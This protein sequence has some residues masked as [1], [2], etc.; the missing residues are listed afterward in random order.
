MLE[1]QEPGVATSGKLGAELAA[2]ALATHPLPIADAIAALLAADSEF[3]QRDRVVEVF[4]VELRLLAALVLAARVQFGAGAQGDSPQL[5]ELLRTLRSRGLTD[6][7]WVAL[8]REI[9]RPYGGRGASPH[10]LAELVGLMF[11][12]KSELP[13]LFDELLV[14]RKSETVAHGATGTRSSVGTVLERRVPQLARTLAL[15]DP[16]WERVRVVVPLA[17]PDDATEPQP[18]WVLVGGTPY[19]GRFR[20]GA[21]AAG[22]R[23]PAGEALLV[24]AEGKPIIALHPIVLVRKPSPETY[25]EVFLLD[26]SSKKGAV[27][28]AVPSMAEHREA[29]AWSVIDA[30]LDEAALEA[31]SEAPRGQERPFRGLSS[32]GPEH[33]A[34]FFG[35]EEQ[36]ER[37]ANRVRRNGLTT[38]TGPSGSGKTSL[39]SAG[40]VPLLRDATA[41]VL[42]PGADPLAS[43]AAALSEVGPR[44][45]LRELAGRAPR[46]LADEVDR[47]ARERD[48]SIIVI[49]DQAEELLTLTPS[50]ADREAFGRAI[51]ALASGHART[52][53]VLSVREDFFARLATIGPLAGVYNLH[54]EVVTTPDR[55]AL[56]RTLIAPAMAFGYA[57]EDEALVTSMLDDV[58]GAP[59]ALALLSFCADQLWDR[60]DRKWKRLTWDAYRALGGVAGA[61][62]THADATLAKLTASE[63]RTCRSLFLRLVTG[64]RTRAVAHVAELAAAL[65]DPAEAKVVIERLA[66]ARLLTSREDDSETHDS[67]HDRERGGAVVEIVHEALIRHWGEL[68]RWLSEDVDGQRLLA[69]MRA[70]TKEWQSRDR[71]RSLLWSGDLLAELERFRRRSSDALAG[72]EAEFADA[73]ALEARRGRRIRIGLHRGCVRS[74]RRFLLFSLTQWRASERA[75][76]ALATEQRAT[77][78]QKTQA[79]VRGLVAEARGFEPRGRSDN[80]LALLRA[81]SS[82]EAELGETKETRLSLDLERLA[83]SGAGGV[84]LRGHTGPVY[85]TCALAGTPW[86]VTAGMD[87]SA[88]VW[89]GTTGAELARSDVQDDVLWSVACGREVFAFG[90]QRMTSEAQGMVIIA[91]SLTAQ[92]IHVIS[93][94]GT[95]PTDLAFTPDGARL[96]A[97]SRERLMVI[98]VETGEV[99]L[100]LD[101]ERTPAAFALDPRGESLAIAY[102]DAPEAHLADRPE[103]HDFTEL[104]I[105]DVSTGRI[106]S[107]TRFA[108][109]VSSIDLDDD[110]RLL[111][112]LYDAPRA[113]LFTKLEARPIE[114]ELHGKTNVVQANFA[115]RGVLVADSAGLLAFELD[116]ARRFNIEIS[117]LQRVALSR[118]RD[119]AVSMDTSSLA[120]LWDLETGARLRRMS[121]FEADVTDAAFDAS[122]ER[123]AL[124]STDK[125]ARVVEL[126]TGS[127]ARVFTASEPIQAEARLSAAGAYALTA[128]F[129]GDVEVYPLGASSTAGLAS[130]AVI[131]LPGSGGSPAG[132]FAFDRENT[133]VAID[134]EN[135]E[136]GDSSPDKHRLEVFALPKGTSSFRFG[137]P[138]PA[139][140]VAFHPSNGSIAVGLNDG[141]LVFLDREGHETN[142]IAAPPAPSAKGRAR[143]MS[144][145]SLAYSP[146]GATLAVASANG[147]LRV[148]R[149][150]SH[151]EL[152]NLEGRTATTDLGFAP[153]GSAL[154][155]TDMESVRL[156][157]L[158]TGAVALLTGHEQ[159]VRRA[160][161]SPDGSLIATASLDQTI[162]LHDRA[163]ARPNGSTSRILTGHTGAVSSVSFSSDGK[164]LLSTS[165][166]GTARVWDL[167]LDLELEILSPLGGPLEDG[168]FANDEQIAVVSTG[169]GGALLASRP[170]GRADTLVSS[171]ELTP[172]RVCRETL[173]VVSVIPRPGPDTVWAPKEFCADE[174][175]ASGARAPAAP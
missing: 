149:E 29:Q 34:M 69:S 89:D 45:R 114:L 127:I 175:T 138:Q 155:W 129:G 77:T 92:P 50:Q 98:D 35:R 125:S 47:V 143:L 133:R 100:A 78:R 14:M 51:V 7:Q 13:K 153:D 159:G 56:M 112:G 166:D 167:D 53:A 39:L 111:A 145:A 66:A 82:L 40:V 22:T 88:R 3:E 152:F 81:A 169:R 38:V 99:T 87:M 103:A 9:L 18:T 148:L 64:E 93:G 15:L 107:A 91:D 146:D 119:R 94:F 164:R 58:D 31:D 61:L 54:V 115:A 140:A 163:T 55:D 142:R 25:D 131:S 171:G 122:G 79:E 116:G 30:S 170:P 75:R 124:T 4:R 86:F 52:R 80:A 157:E 67:E 11:G 70:A 132:A 128:G 118:S 24:D 96:V 5:V 151:E 106:R 174:V 44:D 23:V 121:G 158:A 26:G 63:R 137:S 71:P 113:L 33:A 21:L 85:R 46:E 123:V 2:R 72:S 141:A 43:L 1:N 160:V 73:C 105:A 110:G 95:A 27:Y 16:L 120:S 108:G 42:R 126:R 19:A 139:T 156:I 154:V 84:P 68:D 144:I 41:L 10:P 102:H 83:R 37:L 62:A 57:F 109:R 165:Q 130:R 173:A 172:L 65:P 20:R 135:L 36:A 117:G 101:E 48:R 136:A 12:K 168:T 97:A 28:V 104:A 8:I 59:A 161:F 90:T 32:F 147:R 76:D 49:V 150:P 74:H 17:A 134:Y 6:G 162:R 60:R